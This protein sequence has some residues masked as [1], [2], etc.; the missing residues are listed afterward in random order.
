MYDFDVEKQILA[1]KHAQKILERRNHAFRVLYETVIEVEGASDVDIFLILC[2]NLCRIAQ[3]SFAALATY[4]PQQN[5]LNLKSI[6]YRD[7]PQSEFIE[8][9]T[10]VSAVAPRELVD[11]F[12]QNPLDENETQQFFMLNFF[13][14]N[15]IPDNFKQM[16]TSHCYNLACVHKDEL[17]AV[18]QIVLTENKKIR[19]K[20]IVQIYLNLTGMIIQRANVAKALAESEEKYRNLVERA[21][22]GIVI[23]QDQKIKYANPKFYEITGF[24]F[25]QHSKIDFNDL[26]LLDELPKVLSFQQRNAPGNRKIQVVETKI[27]NQTGSEVD[28]EFSSGSI[29]NE[30]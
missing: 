19:M 24:D 27:V 30:N 12:I 22:D 26:V 3:A 29:K 5:H 9:K 21:N 6:V 13:P 28:I 2:R 8:I 17:I 25:K 20:D 23:V 11:R 4:D 15:L 18:A 7:K 10:N 14:D 16:E 1:D